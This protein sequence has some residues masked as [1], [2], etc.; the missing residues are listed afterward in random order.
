MPIPVPSPPAEVN[1]PPPATTNAPSTDAVSE[2]TVYTQVA[3]DTTDAA[4]FS[5]ANVHRTTVQKP[6]IFFYIDIKR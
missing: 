6:N 2:A 5:D 3:V 4:T 1:P